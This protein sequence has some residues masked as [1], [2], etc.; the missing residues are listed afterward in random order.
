MTDPLASRPD[1]HP[2]ALAGPQLA[3]AA[4]EA[5]VM[6]DDAQRIVM[7]NPSGLAMFGLSREQAMGMDLSQLIPER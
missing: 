5:V 1:A 6:V 3:H 2:E 7:I 4:L